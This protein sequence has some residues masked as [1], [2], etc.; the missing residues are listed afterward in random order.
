MRPRQLVRMP[1]TS[2]SPP[3]ACRSQCSTEPVLVRISLHTHVGL[4]HYIC[5]YPM[6]VISSSRQVENSFPENRLPRNMF[7]H[8]HVSKH[9][10]CFV[11]ESI[12]ICLRGLCCVRN[13]VTISLRANAAS[14]RSFL[15][16]SAWIVLCKGP[17]HHQSACQPPLL[18]SFFVVLG[19]ARRA[20][21][22][23]FFGASTCFFCLFGAA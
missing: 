20:R 1:P 17:R 6:F 23:F 15:H 12:S 18:G 10:L 2:L 13:S 16:L 8:A 5:T 4:H 14:G 22:F 21:F 19:P 7:S 9:P 11:R 3:A